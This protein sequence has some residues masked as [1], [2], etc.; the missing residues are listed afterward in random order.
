M[1]G[2]RN[3]ASASAASA[4]EAPVPLPIS[5]SSPCGIISRSPAANGVVSPPIADIALALRHQVELDD[6]ARIAGSAREVARSWRA[7]APGLRAFGIEEHRAGQF[8]GAQQL[9]RASMVA[10]SIPVADRSSDVGR[11]ADRQRLRSAR[12]TRRSDGARRIPPPQPRGI[13]TDVERR[14]QRTGTARTAG[15]RHRGLRRRLD[16]SARAGRRPAGALSRAGRRRRADVRAARHA[17]VDRGALRARVAERPCSVRL[18]HL[19]R[20]DRSR[21]TVAGAR[22]CVRHRGRTGLHRRRVPDLALRQRAASTN[23]P[24]PSEPAPASAGTSIIT[25][26]STES[27]G[28]SDRRTSA[29]SSTTGC[30][31]STARRRNWCA[32]RRWRTWVAAMAPPRS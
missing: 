1:P 3:S 2:S 29:I 15:S 13:R 11:G 10:R 9:E 30:R 27:N 7:Y 8:H 24:R 5:C 18:C 19:R 25:S 23:S 14:H 20:P 16:G 32:E 28:S 17:D 12:Q 26:S 31:R 4:S 21:F 6:V 22:A